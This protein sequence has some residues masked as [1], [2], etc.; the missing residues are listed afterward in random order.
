MSKL[1]IEVTP[2]LEQ[3]LQEEAAKTGQSVAEVAFAILQEQLAPAVGGAPEDV[4]ALF[5]GLPRRSPAD[6]LRLAEA[7]GVKPVERIEDL[8]GGFWPA[9]ESC[10]QFIA[11]LREG[12]RDRQRESN[13]ASPLSPTIP[14]T[15]P[16]YPG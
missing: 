2:E 9:D 8:Q 13:M 12:R 11:W 1:M 6:L 3:R 7:Q 4:G 15:S 5:E 16:A 10:D 14:A